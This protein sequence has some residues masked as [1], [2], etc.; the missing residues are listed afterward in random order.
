MKKNMNIVIGNGDLD[1]KCTSIKVFNNRVSVENDLITKPI[2]NNNHNFSFSRLGQL[3][4]PCASR[5]W[6][7]YHESF[8][9]CS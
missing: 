9:L 6:H 7:R 5:Y 1:S 8:S 2:T 3:S 4:S